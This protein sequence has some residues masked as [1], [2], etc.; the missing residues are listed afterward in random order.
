MALLSRREWV[1]EYRDHQC[2]HKAELDSLVQG[3]PES[4]ESGQSGSGLLLLRHS[5]CDVC[6]VSPGGYS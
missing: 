5:C 2:L 3:P 1:S 4:V 6:S